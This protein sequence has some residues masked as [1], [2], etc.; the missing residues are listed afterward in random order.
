MKTAFEQFHLGLGLMI[1]VNAAP[2]PG[3]AGSRL[4]GHNDNTPQMS[5]IRVSKIAGLFG[6]RRLERC[7]RQGLHI[8]N[9]VITVEAV[10]VDL[11]ALEDQRAL[12]RD[13]GSAR[14]RRDSAV[15]SGR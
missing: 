7:D 3:V 4:L 15:G 12:K 9:K 13:L 6:G 5:F 14:S 1:P 10:P 2:G 8:Q 11:I